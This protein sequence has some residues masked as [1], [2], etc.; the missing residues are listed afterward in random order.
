MDLWLFK[1]LF[2]EEVDVR[3]ATEHIVGL[4]VRHQVFVDGIIQFPY[5]S[6]AHK[7]NKIVQTADPVSDV[8][9]ARARRFLDFLMKDPSVVVP[10]VTGKSRAGEYIKLLTMLGAVAGVDVCDFFVT[11][12]DLILPVTEQLA[13]CVTDIVKHLVTNK[14]E[15]VTTDFVLRCIPEEIDPKNMLVCQR[16]VNF[17]EVIEPIADS[18]E[19][20]VDFVAHFIDS[21]GFP[22]HHKP[23]KFASIQVFIK[24]L[25]SMYPDKFRAHVKENF[26]VIIASHYSAL[27]IT[28]ETIGDKMPVLKQLPEAVTASQHF[29]VDVL[30]ERAFALNDG[31][32]NNVY[33][34]IGLLNIPQVESTSRALIWNLIIE[35]MPTFDEFK[36]AYRWIGDW[37]YLTK[38]LVKRPLGEAGV[39]ESLR[40]CAKNSMDAFALAY[41]WLVENGG[42][43]LVNAGFV[44]AV[45]ELDIGEHDDV[46]REYVNKLTS[47]DQSR[48][49]DVLKPLLR[50]VGLRVKFL[51]G[52]LDDVKD[53]GLAPSDIVPLFGPLRVL[54]GV[55]EGAA[56]VCSALTELKT[57]CESEEIVS[58]MNVPEIT[59]LVNLIREV[60]E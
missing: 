29:S 27:L 40:E 48:V 57:K 47:C 11:L 37:V 53:D 31:E 21:V 30:V 8:Q 25:A 36:S 3:L 28:L 18:F 33:D 24:K 13:V 1:L 41:P 50:S 9:V 14:C 42:D 60:I 16:I 12:V 6:Y 5:H 52:V 15:L 19:P 45:M 38:Y 20:P 35:K 56:S 23:R 58:R 26:D 10:V 17:Y 39:L 46:V 55:K 32:V 43:I 51:N 34:I 7:F 2:H 4:L 59:T 49:S 44:G 22:S 54:S